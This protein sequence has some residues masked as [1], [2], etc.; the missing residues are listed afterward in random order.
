MQLRL[1]NLTLR[2]LLNKDEDE[3][4]VM[5]THIKKVYEYLYTTRYIWMYSHK[6]LSNAIKEKIFEMSLEEPDAFQKYLV[7]FEYVCPYIR[8]DKK[9]CN[10]QV[11]G[12]GCCITHRKCMNRLEKRIVSSIITLP[13]DICNIVFKYALCIKE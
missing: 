5:K 6:K 10:K 3:D 4:Y 8:L 2:T 9:I 11:D 1:F 12:G 13:L 7:L